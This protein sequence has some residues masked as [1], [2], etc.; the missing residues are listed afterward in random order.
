[1]LLIH[2]ISNYVENQF[3]N[4]TINNKTFIHYCNIY[5]I[6]QNI[7]IEAYKC[8]F[9]FVFSRVLVLLVYDLY[10]YMDGCRIYILLVSSLRNLTSR[11][12]LI[13]YGMSDVFW[14]T[15]LSASYDNAVYSAQ[16]LSVYHLWDQAIISLGVIIVLYWTLHYMCIFV[17]LYVWLY[18][19]CYF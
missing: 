2:L 10:V 18:C 6:I 3:D 12:H 14:Y 16:Y 5:Y 15:V 11:V 4:T 8:V 1:M 9:S 7:R 17:C 13:K 19:I